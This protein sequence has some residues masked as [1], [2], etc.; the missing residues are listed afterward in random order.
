MLF[1]IHSAQQTHAHVSLSI[2]YYVCVCLCGSDTTAIEVSPAKWSKLNICGMI[3]AL[4]VRVARKYFINL[5]VEILRTVHIRERERKKKKREWMFGS[6][7]VLFPLL[8][9]VLWPQTH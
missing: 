6:M 1:Q 9:S 4:E 8:H 3:Y 2:Q 5:A 7:C